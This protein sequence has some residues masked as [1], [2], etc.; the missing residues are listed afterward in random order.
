MALL[1]SMPQ[2]LFAA[3]I[4]M[5]H[6]LSYAVLTDNRNCEISNDQA[7][8][9]RKKKPL[10]RRTRRRAIA[11]REIKGR[12]NGHHFRQHFLDDPA[13]HAR[14]AGGGP[15]WGAD[16]PSHGRA[17]AGAPGGWRIR[18]TL[19]GGA[20]GGLRH[21]NLR[22]L[23]A[24]L[25]HGVVDLHQVSHL[26]P[27]SDRAARLLE[28]ARLLRVEGACRLDRPRSP[29]D[30]LVLL[31][32]RAEPRIRQCTQVADRMDWPSCAGSSFI[33]G[34]VVNNVRGYGS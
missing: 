17:D 32:E 23:G 1:A 20:C 3:G 11:T 28:N 8:I 29:S 13:H 9:I 26:H 4:R 33:V 12:P 10:G 6:S 22:P 24:D 19:P 25:H 30:L 18:H 14:A 15:A 16:A 21:R 31:E 27:Y 34:H 2:R 5:A 7:R